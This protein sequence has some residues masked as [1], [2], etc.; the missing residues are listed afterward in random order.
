MST[1][2]SGRF[3]ADPDAGVF[4]H[5]RSLSVDRRLVDADLTGSVAWAEALG[6]AEVLS[7]ADVEAI[8]GGLED[9]RRAVR[10]NPA[11]IRDAADEDVHSFVERELVERIGDAGRRLHTG[12]SRNE[13]VSLDFRLYLKDR[14]PS[15]QRD[16]ATLVAALAG[17]ADAS[18]QSVMPSYTH[19]RRA[20]PVLVAHMWLSHATAL[21]RD[22]NRFEAALGEIDVMPLGSGA[23]AGTAYP[24]DVPWLTSRLGFAR[25]AANSIDVSGD[26]DFVATFLYACAM[27]MVHLSRLAED[28]ILFSSEEFGFFEMSDAVATGSSLMPQKKNPDP[29]EL[30]RGKSGRAVGAL[31]GWLTTL[32]GLPLGYN[33]DLQEDKA[34]A[35]EAEDHLIG[36]LQTMAVVVRTLTLRPHVARQAASGLLLA[37]EVADYLVG[38]GL[39]FRLAHEVTGRIVRDLVAAGQDFSSLAIDD[40]RR[41]HAL[42]DE[43][44]LKAITPEAAVAAR[45]TPQSTHPDAVARALAEI[46]DWLA[47]WPRSEA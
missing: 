4:E 10:E 34:I 25:A 39:P 18:G 44:V 23:I 15:L 7:A 21:R 16:I 19:L 29:L 36:C 32:K 37:T 33:K 3:T 46:Y 31:T 14:V 22:V 47:R 1:L 5:G 40:W 30:V 6:R 20:Q 41:Y 2:W 28:L 43:G 9:I 27:T 42:F 8:V 17:Q 12:R 11:L 26:R 24:I 13:Q 38:R 45:R 35:F